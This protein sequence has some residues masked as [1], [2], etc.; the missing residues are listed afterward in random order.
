MKKQ[1][2]LFLLICL[3]LV[4]CGSNEK[5]EKA[6]WDTTEYEGVSA[7]VEDTSSIGL[8]AILNDTTE[9]EFTIQGWVHIQVQ[10]DNEWYEVPKV[11]DI[12]T[13]ASDNMSSNS[14]AV[15]W[16]ES[17]GELP[18]G[19]YRIGILFE[20]DVETRTTLSTWGYFNI[21]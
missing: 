9:H 4:G 5:Y 21:K 20:G 17:Y 2:I 14:L 19:D 1:I 6:I 11:K 18:N 10:K 3:S 13:T 12:V 8:T 16:S 7:T 15:D